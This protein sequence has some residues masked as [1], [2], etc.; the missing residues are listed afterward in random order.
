MRMNLISAATVAAAGCLLVALAD[1]PEPDVFAGAPVS[2]VATPSHNK[3]VTNASSGVTCYTGDTTQN[4]QTVFYPGQTICWWSDGIITPQGTGPVT[5]NIS[6]VVSYGPK[7]KQKTFNG[8][9]TICNT[10]DPSTC[11]D[12]PE[13]TS[14]NLGICFGP[15]PTKFLNAI[16]KHTGPIPFSSAITG[17]GFEAFTG[18]LTGNSLA[19]LPTD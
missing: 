10:S 15:L 16:L 2:F 8:S 7:N 14:W 19:P 11:D 17:S 6:V 18:S 12:I 9:F 5:E 13:Y 1:E 4:P 3:G